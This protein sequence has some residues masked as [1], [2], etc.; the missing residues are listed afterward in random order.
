MFSGKQKGRI[1]TGEMPTLGWAKEHSP[2]KGHKP[3]RNL[4]IFK[5][6]V[7]SALVAIT[8]YEML[9]QGLYSAQRW[10]SAAAIILALFVVALFVDDY[11]AGVP[12]IVW[13]LVGL[14]TVLVAVKGLSLAWSIG[15]AETIRELLRCSTYLVVFTLTAASLSSRRLVG[16]FI[17]G[18]NIVAGAVAGYGVLQRTNPAE[19]SSNASYDVGVGS[20]LGY[21]NTVAVVLGI[22]IVLGLGR[23]TQL[24]NPFSRGLYAALILIFG[25]VLYLTFSPGGMLVL[26]VG[27]VALFAVGGRRLQM[28]TNLLLVFGPLAWLVWK[29]QGLRT[30]FDPV[31][32]ESLRVADGSAFRTYLVI[33]VLAAFLLQVLYAVLVERYE[34]AP[35]PRRTL[36]AAVL[37]AV[38]AGAGALG[39]VLLGEWQ[40][41]DELARVFS[42]GAEE[43]GEMRDGFASLSS[44]YRIKYWRVAWDEWKEHPITG[45]GAGTFVYTWQENRPG[46][47]VTKQVHNVYLEQ[48]T[49]TGVFAFLALAGFALALA[50]YL[51]R[52]SIRADGQRKLLLSSLAAAAIIYL[53]S[54]AF[55]W[56]WY[57]PPSTIFFFALAGVAVRFASPRE[58]EGRRGHDLDRKI[59]TEQPARGGLFRGQA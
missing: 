42:R 43:R 22:G 32:E 31:S 33:A 27:L 45:T 24:R 41:S 1:E 2:E 15:Q 26:G 54:S 57:I 53:V 9:D 38:I 4:M 58:P 14:L 39:F 13:V 56:H 10:L 30:F 8:F 19:Y 20:T 36:G 48:G 16:P 49:E 50:V 59:A 37:V 46:F 40:G 44:D 5:S 35:A 18:L 17:D 6:L 51:L 28:F 3:A 55:E 34:L 23:M 12:R 11:F 21:P 52:A 29:V 47:E 25:V 7:L